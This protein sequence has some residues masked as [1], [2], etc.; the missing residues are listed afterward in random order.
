MK[1]N[2]LNYNVKAPSVQCSIAS[3]YSSTSLYM[4]T[5]DVEVEIKLVWGLPDLEIG[6]RVARLPIML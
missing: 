5:A 3:W 2:S 6:H 4:C 1:K